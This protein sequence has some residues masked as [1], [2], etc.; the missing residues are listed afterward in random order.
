MAP[1]ALDARG[2]PRLLLEL[3]TLRAGD[4]GILKTLPSSLRIG[5]GVV[6]QKEGC[7]ESIPEILE[8]ARRAINLVRPERVVLTPDCG[9]ATFADNPLAYPIVAEAKLRAMVEAAAALRAEL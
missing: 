5:V 4:V 3:C 2:H 1:A 9:F 8:R 6:N 7:I